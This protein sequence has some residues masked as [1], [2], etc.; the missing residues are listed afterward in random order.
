MKHH[1]ICSDPLSKGIELL[2]VGTNPNVTVGYR[3]C[4]WGIMG[5]QLARDTVLGL[6]TVKYDNVHPW[7]KGSTLSSKYVSGRSSASA[8]RQKSNLPTRIAARLVPKAVSSPSID[9]P[10][11]DVLEI[12][13]GVS[14]SGR[15]RGQH[16]RNC[17]SIFI[18][19]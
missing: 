11:N 5:K 12:E 14:E 10:S 3:V 15:F 2:R 19:R 13:V 16:V 8:K 9:Y 4:L 6:W 18:L 17:H 7:Y 1:E